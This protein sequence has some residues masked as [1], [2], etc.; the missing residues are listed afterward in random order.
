MTPISRKNFERNMHFLHEQFYQNMIK[1]NIDNVKSIRG[2]KNARKAPNNRAD[3]HSI[4]E[5]SRMMANQVTSMMEGRKNNS[6][7]D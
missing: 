6:E 4:D 2:I 7:D 5:F 1:I 3:L